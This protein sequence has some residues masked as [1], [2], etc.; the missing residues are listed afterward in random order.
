M[1]ITRENIDKLSE[2]ITRNLVDKRLVRLKA[3]RGKLK[4]KIKSVMLEEL[5]KEDILDK[6]V[7]AL[8][9]KN[10]AQL[11]DDQI[12]YQKMFNL[13]KHKLAKERGIVL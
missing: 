9:K 12:D 2:H 6:E 11:G 3:Q 13:V 1:K 8:I 4:E 7:A 10:T 5:R